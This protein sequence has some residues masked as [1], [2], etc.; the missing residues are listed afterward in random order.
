MSM[1]FLTF[2]DDWAALY[3]SGGPATGKGRRFGLWKREDMEEAA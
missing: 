1:T 2:D 3:D